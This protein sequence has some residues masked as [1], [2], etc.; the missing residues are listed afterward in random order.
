MFQEKGEELEFQLDSKSNFESP[1]FSRHK[2]K[3]KFPLMTFFR[4]NISTQ[5]YSSLFS[6]LLKPYRRI[7][8]EKVKYNKD[9]GE[10]I[11]T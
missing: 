2:N 6:V 8:G 4:K 1:V 9:G 5:V 3:Q 10:K 7:K 11:T